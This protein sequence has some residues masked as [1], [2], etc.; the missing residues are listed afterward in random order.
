M[1]LTSPSKMSYRQVTN[2]SGFTSLCEESPLKHEKGWG[3]IEGGR[4]EWA[5]NYC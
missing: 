1:R 5:D 3:T 2:Q 4:G